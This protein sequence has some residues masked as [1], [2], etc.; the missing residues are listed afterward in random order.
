MLTS[1]T[2]KQ[3]KSAGAALPEVPGRLGNGSLG[4]LLSPHNLR[5]EQDIELYLDFLIDGGTRTFSYIMTSMF[6]D[7]HDR[8]VL[9]EL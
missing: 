7:D 5:Q 3:K 1:G 9:F 8:D 4:A 6:A 2:R